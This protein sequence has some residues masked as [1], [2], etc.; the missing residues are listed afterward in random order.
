MKQAVLKALKLDN[1]I[2]EAHAT[3]AFEL[4][5]YEWK[6]EEAELEFKRAIELNPNYA[7]AEQWY[8]YSVIRYPRRMTEELKEAYK[9]LE[10]D[11][12]AP[13]MSLNMGQTMYIREEYDKAIEYFEKSLAIDPTFSWLISIR[14]VA[15]LQALD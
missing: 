1:T 5:L 9:A 15:I 11:P 2:A 13:V 14:P 6:W 4:A 10:L 8:S 7:T 12:L 3:Y